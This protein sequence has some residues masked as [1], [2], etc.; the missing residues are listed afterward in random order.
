MLRATFI[1]QMLN[2]YLPAGTGWDV[3]RF[4]MIR[5]STSETTISIMTVLVLDRL[6][7][8]IALVLIGIVL[9]G[10]EAGRGFMRTL[11]IAPSIVWL[12]ALV[13]ICLIGG[14][15]ALLK[16][17]G[18]ARTV[19]DLRLLAQSLKPATVAKTFVIAIVAH[20][21]LLL[22]SGLLFDALGITAPWSLRLQVFAAAFLLSNLPITLGGHGVREGT[23]V[24]L[25]TQWPKWS[26]AG[27]FSLS[28]TQAGTVAL[29]YFTFHVAIHTLGGFVAMATGLRSGDS[30]TRSC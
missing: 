30:S 23:V 22:S 25:L 19:E 3:A 4:T 10:P 15:A 16:H 13:V 29:A 18:T 5:R 26:G 11:D 8:L 17:E 20:S 14:G 6:F 27:G 28:L 12:T 21:C 2:L 9:I 7:G 24:L 1:G